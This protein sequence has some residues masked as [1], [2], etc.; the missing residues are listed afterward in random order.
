MSDQKG[1]KGLIQRLLGRSDIYF[2]GSLYMRR[3]RLIH[4]RWFGVRVHH[5]VRSDRDREL[6][7]HPFSF[8]SIILGGGYFEHT[9]GGKLKWFGPGSVNVKRAEDLHRLELP[10]ERPTWTL[11]FRGPMRRSWGFM[12]EEGWVH[13]R[14]FSEERAGRGEAAGPY[15][16]ASSL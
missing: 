5:I 11:V 7:D 4:N 1:A 6:H 16:A 14:K 15:A 10:D 13:W 8:V 2:Y 12:T 9:P 3:F